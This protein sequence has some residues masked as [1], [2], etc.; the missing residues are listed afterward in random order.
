M[1]GV[2]NHSKAGTECQIQNRLVPNE[3]PK[4]NMGYT[5]GEVTSEFCLLDLA[6]NDDLA[7]FKTAVEERS[8]KVDAC[9]SWYY[10]QFGS[11]QMVW[12]QRT[13][14]MIAAL[15]GSLEVLKYIL[16]HISIHRGSINYS[17]GSDRS[18]ALHCAVSGGSPRVV[19]TVILLLSNGADP[20]LE[21]DQGLRASDVITVSPKL[22]AL[23]RTVEKLLNGS[24]EIG[25]PPGMGELDGCLLGSV[26]PLYETAAAGFNPATGLELL[27]DDASDVE[28]ISSFSVSSFSSSPGSSPSLFSSSPV[29]S[30]KSLLTSSTKALSES[31]EK[32]KNYPVDPLLPDIKNSIYTSDEFRMF[33]FKVRPCSRAY[34]HDWTE[35]PFVHPGENARRRDPRRYHYSCVPCPDFRKGACRRADACEYAHGVFECWLHPAQYR[36]R[37]CKDGTS[38]ARRVC[39]FAHTTE[40]LRPLY[41]ST[42]SAVPSPRTTC[43]SDMQSMSPN[44]PASPSS[45][46][47]QPPF[48]PLNTAQSGLS[49][50]PMSPSSVNALNGT[51]TQP[52]LPTLHLP[53]VGL[54]ASRL[55]AALNA[56]DVLLEDLSGLTDFESHLMNDIASLS[57]QSRLNAAVT[58]PGSCTSSAR[59]G[60]LRN[61]GLNVAPTNLENLF[62]SEVVSSPRSPSQLAFQPQASIQIQPHKSSHP[63]ST[64]GLVFSPTHLQLQQQTN[65]SGSQAQGQSLLPPAVQ[66]SSFSLGSLSQVSC[67]ESESCLQGS[68]GTVLHP[69]VAAARAILSQK[70]KRSLSSKDLAAGL[71]LSDWGS[72]TGKLEWAVHGDDLAKLRKSASFGSNV[73]DEPDLSWVQK[74]VKDGPLEAD[75]L[76]NAC[77][78]E[79]ACNGSREAVD[80]SVLGSWMEQ[81]Q[82]DEI[83]A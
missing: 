71:S 65:S 14:V 15:Y 20:T 7:G 25:S 49:T 2:P 69:A 33:S 28:P 78:M 63:R 66:Q 23:K 73:T 17:C 39:F 60:M 24:L 76:P 1:C 5:K 18:T 45:F 70:D 8:A 22:P 30:P 59:A 27:A 77:F 41:V 32:M 55:R 40:E 58:A 29:S 67:I 42:G 61:I 68:R 4:S 53:G 11:T 52:S 47:K 56:R 62:A 82:L 83:V 12:S 10:R 31:S 64:G 51:W 50:P 81:M 43:S 74:L 3:G 6:A 38:C 13:P 37:L 19:D 34:S 44:G 48:S 26:S 54:Q 21:N 75:P 16:S 80:H 57:T 46:L 36:T 35:C 79:M 9:G 72:P